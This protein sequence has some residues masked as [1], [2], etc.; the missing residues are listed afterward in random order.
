MSGDDRRQA[1][2]SV[3][4]VLVSSLVLRRPAQERSTEA[5]GKGCNFGAIRPGLEGRQDGG[6]H[7]AQDGVTTRAFGRKRPLLSG[8]LVLVVPLQISPP[9]LA[10][11]LLNIWEEDQGLYK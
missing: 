4:N 5:S 3:H 1:G 2:A 7:G 6:H 10:P 8:W 11:F 9:L